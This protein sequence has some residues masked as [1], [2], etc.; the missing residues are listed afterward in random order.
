MNIH[1]PF[2]RVA[3]ALGEDD[4]T[5]P[6]EEIVSLN[7]DERNILIRALRNHADGCRAMA[8]EMQI[9]DHIAA[10][11]TLKVEAGQASDL[12][13]KI[14]DAHEVQLLPEMA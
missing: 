8:T 9:R 4:Y 3:K 5:P 1:R 6:E 13:E 12:L 10:V 2:T 7:R 11:L 14:E